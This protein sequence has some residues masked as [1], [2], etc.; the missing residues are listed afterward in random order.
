VLD[1]IPKFVVLV[2]TLVARNAAVAEVSVVLDSEKGPDRAFVAADSAKREPG[3]PFDES[4]GQQLAIGRALKRLGNE[5][6]SD[7]R[8]RVPQV[9]P[10]YLQSLPIPAVDLL[11]APVPT[12]KVK[13]RGMRLGRAGTGRRGKRTA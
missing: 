6:L 7:A 1:E 3:D 9:S 13:R 11:I 12:P 10:S 4:L 8:A 5:I 2:D